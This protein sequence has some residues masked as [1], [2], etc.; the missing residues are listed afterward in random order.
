MSLRLGVGKMKNSAAH[1]GRDAL[2]PDDEAPSFD[3]KVLSLDGEAPS[4]DDEVR[5]INSARRKALHILWQNALR[6]PALPF[7]DILLRE[8]GWGEGDQK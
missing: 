2:W 4:L 3:D 7:C 1:V 8:R 5:S 6:F